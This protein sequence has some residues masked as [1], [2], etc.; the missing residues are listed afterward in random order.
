MQSKLVW[1]NVAWSDY[2]YWQLRIRKH[3]NELIY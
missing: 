3:A 1:T 2:L